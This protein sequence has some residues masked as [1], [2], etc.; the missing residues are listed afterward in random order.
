MG[1]FYKTSKPEMI[2]FMYQLPEQAILGAIKSADAK[3]AAGEQLLSDYLKQLDVQAL[4]PDEEAKNA[5]VKEIENQ[6][7]QH[8]LVLKDNPVE[9]LK[10]QTKIRDLGRNLNE[11]LTRGDLAA[12][13]GNYNIRQKYLEEA[14][15]RA[16]DKDGT[17][18]MQ[19]VDAAMK[20]FDLNYAINKGAQYNLESGKY[21]PYGT[22]NLVNY[23]D[24]SKLAKETAEGW[25]STNTKSWEESVEGI[26]WKK[27]TTESDILG[28]E[29]LAMGIWNTMDNNENLKDYRLQNLRL[30]AQAEAAL[31][32]GDAEA[33]FNRKKD[34][35]FGVRDN[36]N[37]LALKPVL[38][39][40]GEPVIVK[41]EDGKP[42]IN[43]ETGKPKVQMEFVNP[44]DMYRIALAAADKKDKYD[45]TTGIDRKET[46]AY[47]KSLE[48]ANAKALKDYEKE[49][50][51]EAI[52]DTENSAVAVNDF[53]GKT[54]K[55]V[56]DNLNATEEQLNNNYK[57]YRENLLKLITNGKGST[58]ATKL[59]EELKRLLPDNGNADYEGLKTLLANN[60]FHENANGVDDFVESH[61]SSKIALQNK[62]DHWRATANKADEELE[63][64]MSAFELAFY[65]MQKNEIASLN[66][67]EED[68]NSL[69]N[70]PNTP[71]SSKA[72]YRNQLKDVMIK[73]NQTQ[74]QINF[75][76]EG[77]LKLDVTKLKPGEKSSNLRS[78]QIQVTRGEKLEELGVDSKTVRSFNDAL[79]A[80]GKQQ[81]FSFLGSATNA[82][83]VGPD[84]VS[85]TNVKMSELDKWMNDP[86]YSTTTADDGSITVREKSGNVVFKGNVGEYGVATD[87]I[88]GVG[89]NSISTNIKGYKYVN[90]KPQATTYSIFIPAH[91]LRNNEVKQALGQVENALKLEAF[92]RE[93]KNKGEG[94]GVGFR[95][96]L[97]KNTF[98]LP[99][100]QT[101]AGTGQWEFIDDKGDKKLYSD[102]KE[103]YNAYSQIQKAKIKKK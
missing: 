2:D 102:S 58:Q 65:R 74:Q 76:L 23:L 16:T 99:N 75:K 94:K 60:N 22:E 19:D 21:N 4:Y 12:Y 29:P 1:R 8:T 78:R 47:I 81:L 33:I 73:R 63:K 72:E 11:R 100:V 87:D 5:A 103:A 7:K 3:V 84:N 48:L 101:G 10:E 56:E 35:Y 96:Q 54:V 36:N 38:D 44:G 41:G 27:V 59:S 39:E 45:I 30:E 95:Q 6:I 91:E 17:I 20:A 49:I 71:E 26:H 90:G 13:Q 42:V 70:H 9:F 89:R 24:D 79:Q 32:K 52:W 80:L 83:M 40:N 61:N 43:E 18:R 53:D 31:T 98:Y 97:D 67:E 55:E 37:Q 51:A 34:Q 62:R 93:A 88:S 86:D 64:S 15:K 92:Q 77:Q 25:V 82:Q 57:L 66:K 14:K 28:L 68:L 50:N 46:Q 69:I 85:M